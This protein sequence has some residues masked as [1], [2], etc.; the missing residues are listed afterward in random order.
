MVSV[1]QGIQSFK[2]AAVSSMTYSVLSIGIP[3]GMSIFKASVV[4]ILA[5]F[6]IGA[7]I[8]FIAALALVIGQNST[9]CPQ[10]EVS[11]GNSFL[12]LSRFFLAV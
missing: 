11:T 10:K 12:T 1:L 7:G 8:S 9:L 6:V 4:I 5:G 2:L 3:A